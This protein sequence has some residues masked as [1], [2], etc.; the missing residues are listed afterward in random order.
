MLPGRKANTEL[1]LARSNLTV[2]AFTSGKLQ[3]NS[4]LYYNRSQKEEIKKSL[5]WTWLYC[6][7]QQDTRRTMFSSMLLIVLFLLCISWVF[8]L[9]EKG[10]I[11]FLVLSHMQPM[12]YLCYMQQSVRK[13]LSHYVPVLEICLRIILA[14]THSPCDL[15][16]N[17][18]CFH[19]SAFTDHEE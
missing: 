17:Y 13:V 4:Q 2:T 14:S 16:F 7:L 8:K 11:F 6:T 5:Q 19:S 12:V 1:K 15:F 3:G 18:V 9:K 10:F